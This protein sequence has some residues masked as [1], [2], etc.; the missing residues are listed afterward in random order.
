MLP[1][2]RCC[3]PTNGP[4]HSSACLTPD[5]FAIN[6]FNNLDY[7]SS[8]PFP[9]LSWSLLA[10]PL[11]HHPLEISS[12]A[13]QPRLGM[14][15]YT[16]TLTASTLE[17]ESFCISLLCVRR[18]QRVTL[19]YASRCHYTCQHLPLLAVLYFHHFDRCVTV[20][21]ATA[22]I[23][24]L[25]MP[26]CTISFLAECLLKL[27]AACWVLQRKL[28]IRFRYNMPFLIAIVVFRNSVLIL[29]LRGILFSLRDESRHLSPPLPSSHCY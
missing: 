14:S 9:L 29:S 16:S 22:V 10:L 25:P 2:L 7:R 11:F 24:Q 3:L 12:R 8:Y 26:R 4:P 20:L 6:F 19:P 23:D 17:R 28:D 1:D 13:I 21:W 5:H 18:E 27:F 15:T